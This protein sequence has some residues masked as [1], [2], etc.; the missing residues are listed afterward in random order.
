M[1]NLVQQHD[2]SALAALE[3][4]DQVMIALFC[5]RWDRAEAQGADRITHVSQSGQ[6]RALVKS[7]D[8][9]GLTFRAY[10]NL[11]GDLSNRIAGHVKHAAKEVWDM[12]D[13]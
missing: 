10:A 2:R 1:T 7:D 6:C 13:P 12:Y 3:L 4:W 5:L 9:D 8:L 11:R